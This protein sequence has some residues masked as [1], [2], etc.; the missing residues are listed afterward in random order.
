M[1]LIENL[2][3]RYA[4]KKFDASKKV[5]QENI[6]KIKE[7][8]QLSASSYGLQPYKVLIVQNA[9]LRE[10]IK[11][12]AWGQSQ[13]TDASHLFVFC[14]YVDVSDQKIDDYMQLKSEIQS[15]E[16]AKLEGY[17]SFMKAK[18]KE[19]TADDISNWTAKQTYIAMSNALNACAE[20]KIDSTPME[21]FEKEKVSEILGLNDQGLEASLLL[22]VGYRSE[23]DLTQNAAKVRKPLESMFEVI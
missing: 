5:S 22:T 23:E 21:G 20:L 18:L 7:A 9:E 12:F 11:P 6:E 8:I 17:G 1:E 16:I 3:W 19:K 15:V 10:Q 4:T 2:R 14:N 13:I